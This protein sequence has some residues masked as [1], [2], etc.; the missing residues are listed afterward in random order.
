VTDR[1]DLDVE[2]CDSRARTR[3]Q[4]TC[5]DQFS[6][7]VGGYMETDLA[8]ANANVTWTNIAYAL[9]PVWMLHTKWNGQDYLFA[10]NGQTGKLIGDLPIDNGKVTKRF[11]MMFAPLAIIIAAIIF[12]VFGF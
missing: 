5:V 10:M 11:L 3:V 2:E 7:T 8:H 1:Y 4:N 9:L 12:F 6:D